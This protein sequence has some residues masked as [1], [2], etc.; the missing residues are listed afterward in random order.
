MVG[1]YPF[2][3]PLRSVSERS[4]GDPAGTNPSSPSQMTTSRAHL[5]LR[6][7][8][9]VARNL[10]ATS[11]DSVPWTRRSSYLSCYSV[12]SHPFQEMTHFCHGRA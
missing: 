4:S 9:A 12:R 11:P 6:E 5:E 8:A 10:P 1:A 2:N 3:D 7:I